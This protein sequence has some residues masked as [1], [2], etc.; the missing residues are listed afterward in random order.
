MQ[1]ADNPWV[2]A[3]VGRVFKGG[4]RWGEENRDDEKSSLGGGPKL[5]WLELTTAR[6]VCEGKIK[7]GGVIGT[8]VSTGGWEKSTKGKRLWGKEKPFGKWG[9]IKGVV[10]SFGQLIV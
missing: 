9:G 8:N 2:R 1:S 10:K 5:L 7:I 4:S 3:A 6:R